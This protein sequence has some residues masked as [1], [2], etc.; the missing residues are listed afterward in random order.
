MADA[1]RRQDS[2]LV[3]NGICTPCDNRADQRLKLAL[4]RTAQRDVFALW[5]F[6]YGAIGRRF[7]IDRFKM[8]FNLLPPCREDECTDC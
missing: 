5:V 3:R 2:N 6:A 4:S 8:A 1:K 7:S